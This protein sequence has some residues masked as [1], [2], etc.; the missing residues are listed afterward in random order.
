MVQWTAVIHIPTS[1]TADYLPVFEI[2]GTVF[3]LAAW[4]HFDITSP[5]TAHFILQHLT[6]VTPPPTSSVPSTSRKRRRTR[7]TTP[8]YLNAGSS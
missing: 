2:N 7:Y 5:R 8:R 3:V 4:S 1:R 6:S